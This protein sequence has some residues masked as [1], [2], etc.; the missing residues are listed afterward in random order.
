MCNPGRKR[1]PVSTSPCPWAIR[2]SASPPG[3]RTSAKLLPNSLSGRTIAVIDND[4]DVLEGMKTLLGKWGCEIYVGTSADLCLA[5]L[6]DHDS[7]PDII[8][9]DYH[10]NGNDT[11]ISAI[12][13]IRAEFPEEGQ[14]PIPAIVITSDRAPEL[15]KTLKAEN[16]PL[17]HK[18]VAVASLHALIQHL[19]SQN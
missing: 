17:I 13:E 1:G 15:E 2:I 19:L 18:P 7:C 3:E 16:L 4:E 14:G 11:G 10:L 8:I 5:Q 6:I 9:A 12:R